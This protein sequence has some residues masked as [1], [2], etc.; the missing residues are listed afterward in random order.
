MDCGLPG[1]NVGGRGKRALRL[2]TA[3]LRAALSYFPRVALS[4]SRVALKDAAA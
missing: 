3:T 4:H 2:R 1:I